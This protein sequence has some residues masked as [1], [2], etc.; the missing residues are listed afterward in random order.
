MKLTFLILFVSSVYSFSQ[1]TEQEP[2]DKSIVTYYI[3]PSYP[4][5]TKACND[6]LQNFGKN[7]PDFWADS[8]YNKKGYVQFIVEPD[9]SVSTIS[10]LKS[11]SPEADAL[12]IELI[13][14]MPKWTPGYDKNGNIPC[15]VRLPIVFNRT[16][17]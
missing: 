16:K 12:A 13:S 8:N 4:G 15:K 10:M 17:E 6:Y 3:E 11:I 7:T 1:V 2:P 14:Q 9:G 5:G